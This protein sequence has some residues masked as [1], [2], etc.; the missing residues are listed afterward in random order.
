MPRRTARTGR[1]RLWFAFGVGVLLV[2]VG[3]YFLDQWRRQGVRQE[4]LQALARRDYRAARPLFARLATWWVADGEA[5]FQL[6]VCE[7]ALGNEQ[8]ARAAWDSVPAGSSH[9]GQAAVARARQELEKHHLTDAESLLVRA[10]GDQGPHATEAFE[11]LVHLLKIEGRFREARRLVRS[12]WVHYPNRIGIL[13]ELAKLDTPN[14]YAPDRAREMLSLAERA[15][16]DD[17]RIGLGFA[18]LAI[19]GNA[20]D[21]AQRRL[22][23]LE[24]THPNDPAIVRAR[25]SLALATDDEGAAHEALRHLPS[26]GLDPDE[27]LRLRAWFANRAG[28]TPAERTALDDMLSIQPDPSA[29]ERLA[30]L[31][32]QAGNTTRSSDLRARKAELD[33]ARAEYEALLLL[34]EKPV[35]LPRLAHLAETLG[36]MLEAKILWKLVLSQRPGDKEALDGVARLESRPAPPVIPSAALPKLLADLDRARPGQHG[37]EKA[38]A[39]IT[40]RV[41]PAFAD[42]SESADLRFTFDSGAEP[43]HHLPEIY[44]GG[45]GLL[46]YDGDG[47]L[48]VYVVQGGRFPPEPNAPGGDRLFRNRGDGTFE[49]V[50]SASRVGSLVRGYGHGLTV[51]DYDNDGRP[52]LFLTRWRGYTLLHNKGDGTFEDATGSAGLAGD[53]DLPTSAAFADFDGDGD[54]DLY[55][56]H[57]A[58]W[59]LD[60]PALWPRYDGR[61]HYQYCDPRSLPALSDHLFRNDGGKFTDVTQEAG[62]VDAEGRGLGVVTVDLDDDGKV[63]IFVTNDTSANFLFRNL[64]GMRFEE[65]AHLAGVASKA[66]GGYMAGM[67]V[68]CGDLDGDGRPDL[69]VTN[70][71]GES[72]TF[73]HN[74]GQGIFADHT[75][76]IG[77][78]VPTRTSLGFGTAFLDVNND[79]YLDLAATNG[80]VNDFRPE[81]PFQMPSQLFLGGPTGRLTDVSNQAGAPWQVPR[82]GRGLAVGDLDN[83]GLVDLLILA[84]NQPL[85]YFHNKT[86]S[87]RSHALTLGL[88]G[89]RSNRDAVGARVVVEAGGKRLSG[90]RFGGGSFQSASSPRLHF[91]L[92]RAEK[93]DRVEVHWPSGAV[94]QFQDLAAGTGYLIREGDKRP[95]PL[96]GFRTGATGSVGNR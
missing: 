64:G 31:E 91:G 68:A 12:W 58:V 59:D 2:A 80:H 76:A 79:G 48:D 18:N 47:W 55:V 45:I 1:R 93:A 71:Y 53:R 95:R 35:A 75:S 29:L 15:A 63:D 9:A 22:L 69:A 73:Y 83:D 65:I 38:G 62:I 72:M 84:Q 70:F 85:A 36:G 3:I 4:A 41:F 60:H 26:D 8:A 27:V 25:L 23:R 37:S 88:E 61:D 17:S 10:L 19:R 86:A 92:G 5:R 87:R 11:T 28:D 42:D 56:C 30:E 78:E 54:L 34:P 52:D 39:E 16:P 7:A 14:A 66:S 89:V 13:K 82:V 67:G 90:F 46:D 24:E 40:G 74:L 57:Y 43:L 81:V 32:F 49:D 94:D 51:G 6:G 21:E 77:L 20:L 96:P 44:S 50:T 33:R